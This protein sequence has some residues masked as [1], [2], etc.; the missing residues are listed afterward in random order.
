M[1]VLSIG[2]AISTCVEF[3]SI[4]QQPAGWRRLIGV[5]LHF[6]FESTDSPVGKILFE[7]QMHVCQL[8]ARR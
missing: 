7:P 5:N 1:I 3:I 2:L 8:E 4:E 6:I